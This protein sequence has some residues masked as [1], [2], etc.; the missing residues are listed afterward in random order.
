MQ[1]VKYYYV[2]LSNDI[3]EIILRLSTFYLLSVFTFRKYK[4]IFRGSIFSA[5]KY[6]YV[7]LSNDILEIILRLSNTKNYQVFAPMGRFQ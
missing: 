6:Y 4:G 2:I 1:L 3:L 7:A 5:I